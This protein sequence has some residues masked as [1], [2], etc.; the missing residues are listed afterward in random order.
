MQQFFHRAL[1]RRLLAVSVVLLVLCTLPM[2]QQ[3][4]TQAVA[5]QSRLSP[6]S[7][8]AA[9][10]NYT[11]AVLLNGSLKCWGDN[12]AGNLGL[13]N[14]T[15]IG[16]NSSEV[17]TGI[18]A[19]DIGQTVKYVAAGPQ[20]TTC[21]I[22]ADDKT[23]CWGNGLFGMLGNGGN[24]LSNLYI[25]DASGE[26]GSALTPVDFG[27][28]YAVGLDI[29]ERHACALMAT[30]D[31][32]CWGANLYGEVGV[33]GG[34]LTLAQMGTNWPSVNLGTGR[35]ALAVTAGYNHTCAI[36]DTT[37][38]VKCWGLNDLGQLGYGDTTNRGYTA[39]ASAS[40][41]TVNLGVGRTAMAIEAGG[42]FTCA[43]LDDGT[44]K[45]WGYNRNG[46]LG[47]NSTAIIGDESTEMAN[48]TAIYLG[49]GRTAKHIAVSQNPAINS[50][51]AILDD[52]SLKCWGW[53]GYGQLGL[54]DTSDRGDES[55][56]MLTLGTVNLGTGQV[57]AQIAMGDAHVCVLL[58]STN[59]KCFGYG[60]FGQLANGTG[61]SYGSRIAD[62]GDALPIVDLDG[63]SPTVT[64]TPT[65]SVTSTPNVTST[66]SK[67]YTRTMT[68]TRSK[69]PTRSKT[70]TKTKTP[71]KSKTPTRTPVGYV[72]R[73]A[74]VAS[75][76]SHSCAI[77]ASSVV[78]CWGLNT[79]G[80]LGLG[81]TADRGD[82]GGEMG[83]SLPAVDLG[84][85]VLAS[86]IYAGNDHTC[87]LTTTK[88]VK[89]W[90]GN[91]TGQLGVGDTNHRG[92]GSGEMGE[93]LPYV[94]VGTDRTATA[95]ALGEGSTC[96]L[97]DNATVVCWGF[98][99]FGQLGVGSTDTIGDASGEMGDALLPVDVGTG[100]TVKSIAA[101]SLGYCA[102]LDDDSIKCW[103]DNRDGQLGVGDTDHRGDSS[104]EM[105]DSLARVPFSTDLTPV[106][107]AADKYS[108]CA[109][110]DDGT[111]RCWGSNGFGALGID[112][113]VNR[114]EST[115][116]IAALSAIN[117][118]SG[119]T[120][121]R[122]YGGLGNSFCTLLD[123]NTLK[124]WGDNSDANLG[125]G[126]GAT[127]TNWGNAT[128]EM[129]N[130]LPTI[131]V[132]TGTTVSALSIGSDFRCAILTI[133]TG[134]K[135]WGE[136][137][138]GQ[139]G[140]G[141]TTEDYGVYPASDM[142]DALPFVRLGIIVPSTSTP[143]PTKTLT[144][145]RTKSPTKT[146]SPTRTVTQTRT[147]T[148]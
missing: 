138:N 52:N 3:R 80:Q 25:G 78:K 103:G 81:D 84:T 55:G 147:P 111:V 58:T 27:T 31:V 34:V 73:V 83:N 43:L 125:I 145:S 2:V 146:L 47:Q 72:S 36:L 131:D 67:T 143:T 16:D 4:G 115:G 60:Y 127:D 21:A 116:Q 92:D 134:V 56:E 85:G 45:C 42:F 44:V 64:I 59:I 110:F 106:E 24:A 57:P 118:G 113:A 14:T 6:S 41:P 23:V 140:S 17:G 139:L 29:G 86:K 109:R 112:D 87:I 9:S 76:S 53:N 19:T 8:I 123:D 144:P 39:L 13:G 94:N 101:R 104:G 51:C 126:V 77:L 70:K 35:T 141:S 66:P 63:V 12:G 18:L 65:A 54:G 40:M 5:A 95:L 97:L 90:G 33:D 82:A 22:R 68:L 117:L 108:T 96:A 121:K 71:T 136:N 30:G 69:T 133:S 114:G 50:V 1:F 10:V 135:C 137:S 105:G 130:T 20:G 62:M 91:G 88:R 46:Q 61:A 148:P 7:M 124:C 132:G 11:C 48:L 89:C 119:H 102:L 98:N 93:N 37:R 120:A 122:I 74:A 28:S 15:T 99:M 38:D 107:L 75:G 128:G 100:R 32:K 142:G 26:M 49:D 79:N 129:G